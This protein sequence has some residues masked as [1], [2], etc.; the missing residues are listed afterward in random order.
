MFPNGASSP[1]VRDHNAPEQTK[2]ARRKKGHQAGR[3]PSNL[4]FG[5]TGCLPASANT[6]RQDVP[7]FPNLTGRRRQQH[8]L[9]MRRAPIEISGSSAGRELTDC[10]ERHATTLLDC[11]P[12]LTAR[13]AGRGPLTNRVAC[14]AESPAKPHGAVPGVPLAFGHNRTVPS[15]SSSV[16]HR[17]I[18]QMGFTVV[19]YSVH[20]ETAREL[21]IHLLPPHDHARKG[22][23]G[24]EERG[25][26]AD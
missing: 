5:A 2:R 23:D 8:S 12:F 16:W 14:Q 21:D 4:G 25:G 10:S 17:S 20:G 7:Q 11:D 9:R 24:G 26:C 19:L 22:K 1:N 15:F 13:H 3:F 18:S 6:L